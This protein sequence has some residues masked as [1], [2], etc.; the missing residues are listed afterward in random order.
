M[1]T[2]KMLAG[3]AVLSALMVSSASAQPVVQEPGLAAFYHP[4]SSLGMG[5]SRPAADAMAMAPRPVMRHRTP[6]PRARSVR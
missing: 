4:D 5:S 2:F 1:T 3:A 6:M